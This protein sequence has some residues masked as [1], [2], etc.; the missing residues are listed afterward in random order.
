MHSFSFLI[1]L[2]CIFF[3]CLAT[4]GWATIKIPEK[5]GDG[6]EV[7]SLSQKGIKAAPL[8]DMVE[9]IK[10]G[11]YTNIHS[12]LL[13]KNGKLVFE[14]Y[15]NGY[16]RDKRH[17]LRSATK[18]IGSVL[19]GIAID[20]GY[21]SGVN[22]PIFNYFE[23]RISDWNDLSRAVTIKSLLTM[24]SGF[25]CD[26]HGNQAFKC[27]QAMHQSD[28][29]V[30]FAL[31]L[32][33]IHPPGSHWAYNSSSLILL[34]EMISKSSG[35]S[36]Q[37]FADKNLMT[38]LGIESFKWGFSPKGLAWLAG[39]AHMRPRDMAKFGQMCLMKGIWNDQRI[40]SENWLKKSTQ[41]HSHSEY[42]MEYGYLWWRGKQS[43]KGKIIE[44][45]W[46][47]GNGGQVIFVCPELDLVAVFTGGNFNSI[48]EFQ[49]S[50]M[51]INYIIPAILP[52]LEKRTF[53]NPD[54]QIF[55]ALPGTYR[56]KDLQFDLI[57][58]DHCLNG[59]LN[60]MEMS[61]LF[62]NKVQFLMQNSVFGNMTG[63]I[64]KDE[65]GYPLGLLINTAFSKLF[66]QRMD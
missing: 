8:V 43:V 41:C 44:A 23:N 56:C 50:G 24:T 47:Q 36:V 1:R 9:A 18:S 33:I 30:E 16:D 46:A 58:K 49:F 15:F 34:S 7:A 52:G 66:F 63:R 61:V 14:E 20:Q 4:E 3:L 10:R 51:L 54:A 39:N 45:F 17:P 65:R 38:P 6:W 60:G 21:F 59:R 37:R 27:E 25:E 32:P 11:N 29:W 64:L 53:I 35:L 57:A 22:D 42:G 13:I 48:L 5:T 19:V 62:E 12:V 31:K 40:V 28:D 55:T 2:F 26:D